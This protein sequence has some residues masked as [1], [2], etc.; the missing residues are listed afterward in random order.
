MAAGGRKVVPFEPTWLDKHFK[1][2]FK[3]LNARSQR[4]RKA[5]LIELTEA[6][7]NSSHPIQDPK[8]SRYRR[9]SYRGVAQIDGGQLVEYRLPGTLRVIVCFFAQ[10]SAAIEE[11]HVVLMTATLNHDHERMKRL[12]K[13]HRREV[14]RSAS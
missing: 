7:Q 13:Q 12:I 5:Q 1:K 8:L 3:K 6:L 10:G 2:A 11:E 9:S 4:E 14:G